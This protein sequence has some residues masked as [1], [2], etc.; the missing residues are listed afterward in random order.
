MSA[1]PQRVVVVGA[2]HGGVEL[3]AALR[4]RGFDGSV[5]VVGEEPFLPYQRPPLSKEFLKSPDDGGLPL[6]GAAF[7]RD[8]AV[9]LSVGV[10]DPLLPPEPA[11]LALGVCA[12][13][14]HAVTGTM[15]R[16]ESVQNAVDQARHVAARLTGEDAPYRAV[17]WFWSNQG[18]QRLQ[19]AGLSAGHDDAVQRGDPAG[20]RF[21]IF[22]Y[23]GETM[24]AVESINSAGDHM[25]ARRL[26]DRGLS[27]PKTMAAD[28]ATDLKTLL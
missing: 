8:K 11:Q 2:G 25:L 17:P 15:A 6:K 26:L 28:L 21:S 27:V 3:A 22:L 16:L 4:Q 5:T 24:L 9:D 20:D 23:R 7:F 10:D 18:S 14:P 13:Y 19:I 1:A 12:A